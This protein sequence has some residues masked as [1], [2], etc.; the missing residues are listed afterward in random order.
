MS[1]LPLSGRLRSDSG[2]IL[3]R[4]IGSEPDWTSTCPVWAFIRT[5]HRFS[6]HH[7]TG[8]ARNLIA[9]TA[10][11]AYFVGTATLFSEL[12]RFF[13]AGLFNVKSTNILVSTSTGLPL[14]TVR[15]YRHCLTASIVAFTSS[16]GPETY[17]RR[18]IVPSLAMIAHSNTVP[19]IR[20]SA[21]YSG[22]TRWMRAAAARLGATM[23]LCGDGALS[24]ITPDD[25]EQDSGPIV[26]AD[27]CA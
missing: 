9:V 17:S 15:L 11:L 10:C 1:A 12:D 23:T 14:S 24:G 6:D 20:A 26:L 25:H 4:W 3:S 19:S 2:R 27:T 22:S 13:D 5:F 7:E 21:G 8:A 16:T 18:S